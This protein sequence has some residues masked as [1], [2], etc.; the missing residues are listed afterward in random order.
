MLRQGLVVWVLFGLWLPWC[1]CFVF[2]TAGG[3]CTTSLQVERRKE[4]GGK[5]SNRRSQQSQ[6]KDP[7]RLTGSER[8]QKFLA[9]AGID[10][11][12]ACEQM[13]LDGRVRVNG[14]MVKELGTR[15]NPRGDIVEVDMKRVYVKAAQETFWYAL[16]KP[17]GVITT[18]RDEE[19]RRSV[20]DLVPGADRMRLVPVGRL[21]KD[22]TGLVLLTNDNSWVH[23]LTH[24]KFGHEKVYRVA[25]NGFP[26]EVKWEK[27][28][29]GFYLPG[30]MTPTAPADIEIL[31]YD[32]RRRVCVFD[33][34]LKEGRNRQIRRMCEELGHPVRSINRSSLG[35]IKLKSMRHGEYRLLTP[36]EV[37]KIKNVAGKERRKPKH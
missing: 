37:Q 6:S 5:R 29:S 23:A 3:K 28:A 14:K 35:P 21:D 31:D 26:S 13:I 33:I 20:I 17:K 15:V 7:Y 4:G 30:E 2:N 34:T 32:E 16:N 1:Y 9:H 36:A 10:S 27:M 25:I 19:G 24:P 18:V 22:S 11:R 8:L 12:R